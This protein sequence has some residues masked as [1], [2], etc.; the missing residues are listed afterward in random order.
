MVNIG[1]LVICLMNNG[2]IPTSDAN[3]M[4]ARMGAEAKLPVR[5]DVAD[6]DDEALFGI[7]AVAG[8]KETGHHPDEILSR[9]LQAIQNASPLMIQAVRHRQRLALQESL[10]YY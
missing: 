1:Q 8:F 4:L 7:G 5:P 3:T 9:S 10:D 2:I 6:H